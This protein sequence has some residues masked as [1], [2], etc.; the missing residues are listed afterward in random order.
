[1][2]DKFVKISQK[3]MYSF[4]TGPGISG[5]GLLFREFGHGAVPFPAHV[6]FSLDKPGGR[7][8]ALFFMN[9]LSHAFACFYFWYYFWFSPAWGPGRGART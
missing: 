4:A 8:V 3:I 5:R 2:S 7:E 6:I 1:L 9:S